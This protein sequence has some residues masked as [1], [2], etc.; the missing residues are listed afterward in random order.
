MKK[1]TASTPLK[2]TIVNVLLNSL[3]HLAL[4]HAE[5]TGDSPHKEFRDLIKMGANCKDLGNENYGALLAD[6]ICV[7]REHEVL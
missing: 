6:T 5:E 7:A 1:A 3:W 4:T 2:D